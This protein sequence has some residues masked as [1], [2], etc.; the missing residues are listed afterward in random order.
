MRGRER[1]REG[2]K[3]GEGTVPDLPPRHRHEDHAVAGQH[4]LQPSGDVVALDGDEIA[5]L[6]LLGLGEGG[7]EEGRPVGDAA[8]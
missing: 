4:P 5:V 2:G 7:L 3:E 8:V 1:G 6:E